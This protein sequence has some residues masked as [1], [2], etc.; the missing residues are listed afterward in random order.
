MVH[1][2]LHLTSIAKAVHRLDT[3]IQLLKALD[4]HTYQKLHPGNLCMSLHLFQKVQRVQSMPVCLAMPIV[5][6]AGPAFNARAAVAAG[7][8]GSCPG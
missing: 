1:A 2:L 6:I 4:Q 8:A 5:A 3:H 7:L